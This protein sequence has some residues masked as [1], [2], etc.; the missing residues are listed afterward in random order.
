MISL[1]SVNSNGKQWNLVSVSQERSEILQLF[2]VDLPMCNLYVVDLHK[3]IRDRSDILQLALVDLHS[4][5]DL[6]LSYV[7]Q[8]KP[9]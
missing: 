7:L 8:H 4:L 9:M 6:Q 5:H 2:H 1:D 3:R